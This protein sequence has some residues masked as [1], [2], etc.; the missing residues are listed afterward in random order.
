MD[1]WPAACK[2]LPKVTNSLGR[3]AKRNGPDPP[4]TYFCTSIFLLVHFFYPHNSRFEISYWLTSWI[5]DSNPLMASLPTSNVS[6]VVGNKFKWKLTAVSGWTTIRLLKRFFSSST[7]CS[8]TTNA[9]WTAFWM[10][11][12]F[13]SGIGT[14]GGLK[15][16]V[17]ADET[18]LVFWLSDSEFGQQTPKTDGWLASRQGVCLIKSASCVYM[19]KHSNNRLQR[20][21]WFMWLVQVAPAFCCW[22]TGRDTKNVVSAGK[23]IWPQTNPVVTKRTIQGISTLLFKTKIEGD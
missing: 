19:K 14:S 20:P 4:S 7:R 12:G 8:T 2:C 1:N 6:E 18:P 5:D 22:T 15:K 9:A 10:S 11:W 21:F 16:S 23:K 13:R 17:P 3:T